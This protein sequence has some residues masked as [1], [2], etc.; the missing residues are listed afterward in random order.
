MERFATFPR[1]EEGFLLVRSPRTARMFAKTA[2]QPGCSRRMRAR[3][4]AST[5]IST[6]IPVSWGISPG[7]QHRE[8]TIAQFVGM[9]CDPCL[10]MA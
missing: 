10:L 3:F 2:G 1:N 7:F 4:Q 8:S 9:A 5:T 6:R